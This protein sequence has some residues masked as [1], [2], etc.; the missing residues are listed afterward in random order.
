MTM[1]L[2]Y[3]KAT[4]SEHKI[5]LQSRLIYAVWRTGVARAGGRAGFEVATSFVGNGAKIK[6]KGKSEGG[7]NL[8]KINGKIKNDKFIGEFEIPEDIALDDAVYFEVELSQN[9]LSAE[10]NRIPAA[11]GVTVSNMKWSA[12]EARRGDILTLS[13]DVTGCR[14]DTEAQVIIYEHDTDSAHDKIAE[15][16][17]TVTKDKIELIWEY[18]YHEDTDEVPTEEELQKYG[19]SYN[20]PEYFFII[21]IDGQKF[22]QEQESG[23]LLFKDYI[24]LEMTDE[25]GKPLANADYYLV[26][27]DGTEKEGKLDEDGRLRVDDVPPGRYQLHVAENAD[28]DDEDDEESGRDEEEETES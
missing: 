1:S 3:S 27:A 22:G 8:G 6:V 18:E 28:P 25:G 2:K 23:L 5:K 13:A 7:E 21:E 12:G 16:P 15:I 19:S 20:P 11:P 4:D 17:A 10:S 14:D 24:E 26:L 9:G